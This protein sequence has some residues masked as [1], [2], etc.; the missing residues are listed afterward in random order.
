[1]MKKVL[2]LVLA[3]LL[4]VSTVSAFSPPDPFPVVVKVVMGGVPV[5]GQ[6]FTVS[7]VD[8]ENGYVYD[9]HSFVTDSTGK[10]LFDMGDFKGCIAYSKDGVCYAGASRSYIGDDIEFRTVYNG[11]TYVETRNIE[12]LRL[13]IGVPVEDSFIIIDDEHAQPPKI[14]EVP[15]EKPV[16]VVVETPGDTVYVCEDGTETVNPNDC[17]EPSED[18]IFVNLW[19]LA[20]V[21]LAAIGVTWRA[22]YLGLAKYWWNKGEKK[23]AIKMLFTAVKKGKEGAYKKK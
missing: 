5:P 17:E 10:S 19:E 4:L 11:V 8:N 3:F 2:S 14:V 23:R 16:E 9:R 22:G 1:M 6:S 20:G 12:L 21:V 18:G 7:I 13:K 15:V